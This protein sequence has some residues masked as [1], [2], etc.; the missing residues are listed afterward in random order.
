MDILKNT[1]QSGGGTK[2]SN[3]LYLEQYGQ[4]IYIHFGGGDTMY[5]Y[6]F[7]FDQYGAINF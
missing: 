2:Y 1:F 6:V 3:V 4:Y 7:C 5:S